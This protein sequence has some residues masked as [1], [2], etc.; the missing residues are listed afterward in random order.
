MQYK[1]PVQ[2]ENEDPIMLGLSLRQLMII[3]VGFGIAYGIFKK[4]EP[5]LGG[6]IAL[7]PTIF[8]VI[9]TLVV[10]LF[11]NSEM[12]FVPFVLSFIRYKLNLNQRTW[13]SG[14]D[15][16]EPM[17]IGFVPEME[18]EKKENIDFKT[19]MDKIKEIHEKIEKI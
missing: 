11:K 6:Q 10:A 1:I 14:V 9:L 17:D 16:Y 13:K 12:T 2:I 5:T 3:M 18:N 8:V 19:K 15:S 7:I 4:M